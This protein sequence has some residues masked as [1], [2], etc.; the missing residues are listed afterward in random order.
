MNTGSCLCL[1]LWL[2]CLGVCFVLTQTAG[3]VQL[4]QRQEISRGHWFGHNTG[5]AVQS[6]QHHKRYIAMI[7]VTYL[8]CFGFVNFPLGWKLLL[9]ASFWQLRNCG[10][11]QMS[12]AD[13]LLV[14]NGTK[15]LTQTIKS[16]REDQLGMLWTIFTNE[17]N[18]IYF[19]FYYLSIF[20]LNQKLENSR[21][22]F[23]RNLVVLCDHFN[24]GHPKS[25]PSRSHIPFSRVF[26]LTRL[27][28]SNSFSHRSSLQCYQQSSAILAPV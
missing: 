11:Y 16:L 1:S 9:Y 15:E 19:F 5:S 28:S 24:D 14:E 17:L 18:F 3:V 22:Y 23:G 26:C 20:Q 12:P 7:I 2:P 8:F 21:K 13:I 4:N 25:C 6:S 10:N 27:C